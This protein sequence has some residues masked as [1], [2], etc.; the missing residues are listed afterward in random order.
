MSA[1]GGA[2]SRRTSS[3]PRVPLLALAALLT[4][5]AT[6]ALRAGTLADP[7]RTPI[8]LAA[9]EAERAGLRLAFLEHPELPARILEISHGQ[10]GQ[11]RGFTS[12]L[13]AA[14][15]GARVAVAVKTG[16]DPTWLVIAEAGGDQLRVPIDGLLA[17]AF[18][19]DGSWLAATD[20][21][22]RLWQVDVVDGGATLL[23]EGPFVGAL[24]VEADGALL[25]LAVPSVEAPF[26]SR[27]VRIDTDGAVSVLSDEELVYDARR[28][29]D[30]ALAVVT[31]R[32]AGNVLLRLADG[33]SATVVDLGPG[34]VHVTT[35]DDMQLVA[36][37][38]DGYVFARDGGGRTVRIARGTRPQMSADGRV[39]L[40][41]ATGGVAAYGSDGSLLAELGGPAILLGCGECAS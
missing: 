18:A 6:L 9:D 28:L 23:A 14:P 22:G 8:H 21:T 1:P 37:E 10:P 35:S 12:I 5:S 29:P 34:A 19:P 26:S 7:G 38:R 31:H 41:E 13:A 17:A 24:S 39:I 20:G 33:G 40:V 3:L 16:Q 25:A 32:P 30:G 27:L 2:S 36:W 4:M 11:P 15:D